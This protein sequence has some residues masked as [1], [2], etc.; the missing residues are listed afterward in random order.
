M[1]I[2]GLKVGA[3]FNT[4]NYENQKFELAAEVD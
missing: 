1:K 2:V 3:V 4:G